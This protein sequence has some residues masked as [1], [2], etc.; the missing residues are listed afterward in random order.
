MKILLMLPYCSNS[1][2]E[3]VFP[4]VSKR[5][6]QQFHKYFSLFADG[7][8]SNGADVTVGCQFDVNRDISPYKLLHFKGDTENGVGF[9]YLATLNV[10]I[11]GRIIKFV[12]G[13]FYTESFCRKNKCAV[14]IC[15]PNKVAS[16]LGILIGATLGGGRVVHVLSDLPSINTNSV[17]KRRTFRQ[18]IADKVMDKVDGY[19]FFT[20]AMNAL[21]NHNKKPNVV[22]EC[23]VDA[24]MGKKENALTEKYPHRVMMYTGGV[25]EHYGLETLME[26]FAMAAVPD[27]EL[28]IYGGGSFA[29]KLTKICKDY[30]NIRYLGVLSN[31][32]IIREQQKA[33]VLVNPR[34][35]QFEYTKYSFPSKN[36][37]YMSS[38]TPTLTTRLPGMPEEYNEHV[39]LFDGETVP[40]MAEKIRQVYA[41]SDEELHNFGMKTKSWVLKEKNHVHQMSLLVE[42][43]NQNFIP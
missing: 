43:I 6:N 5:T 41:M 19:F 36:M 22:V 31:E 17:G 2:Y 1:I 40:E 32:E 34:S 33:T 14:V 18:R 11:I 38:G 25:V 3:K 26:A 10:P 29:D 23:L 28:W 8:A 4:D 24:R 39:L 9:H 21:V 16:A 20:E 15:D 12:Q 30:I 37:E 35:T 7:L 27:T 42:M 13:I